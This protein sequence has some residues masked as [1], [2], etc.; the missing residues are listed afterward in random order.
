MSRC[1]Q[2]TSHTSQD[3]AQ[4]GRGHNDGYN[5]G[6]VG[7]KRTVSAATTLFT[8]LFVFL[9]YFLVTGLSCFSF[10]LKHPLEKNGCGEK[11]KEEST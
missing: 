10:L 1:V 6:S 7:T 5:Y 4:M 11:R 2:Q 9:S 3:L 8:F